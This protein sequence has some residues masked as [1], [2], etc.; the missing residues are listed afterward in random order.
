MPSPTWTLLA[1]CLL[2]GLAATQSPVVLPDASFATALGNTNNNI[3]FRCARGI[4]AVRGDGIVGRSARAQ[5]SGRC[6][7]W[8]PT[9]GI[10]FPARFGPGTNTTC[11]R[12]W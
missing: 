12:G 5:G 11:R 2:A 6:P 10:P 3:G 7:E 4:R 9:W 1:S 8:K